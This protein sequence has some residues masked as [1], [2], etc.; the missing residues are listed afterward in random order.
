M[1]DWHVVKVGSCAVK[2]LQ[3]HIIER[4]ID[5][6]GKHALHVHEW[7]VRMESTHAVHLN[8]TQDSGSQLLRYAVATIAPTSWI[9]T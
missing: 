1:L 4:M 7:R 3:S 5:I 2:A 9:S 6:T 8:F